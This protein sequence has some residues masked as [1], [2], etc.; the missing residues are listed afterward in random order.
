MGQIKNRTIYDHT[1]SCL[2]WCRDNENSISMPTTKSRFLNIIG[3]NYGY[4]KQ[5]MHEIMIGG[6][7]V[8]PNPNIEYY[9][10]IYRITDKGR[11]YIETYEKLIGLMGRRLYTATN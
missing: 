3:G 4:Y 9:T 1:Y 8:E 10:P 2:V 6:G 11:E 5:F 7:L